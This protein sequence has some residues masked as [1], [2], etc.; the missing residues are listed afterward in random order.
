[1]DRFQKSFRSAPNPSISDFWLIIQ[2]LGKN[3]F[4]R[5][6][7]IP[8]IRTSLLYGIGAGVGLGAVRIFGS[9]RMSTEIELDCD[10]LTCLQASDRL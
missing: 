7:K 3:D 4:D 1:M 6:D 5:F 2:R 9:G 10:R 8:C